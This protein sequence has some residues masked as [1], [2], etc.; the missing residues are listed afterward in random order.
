MFYKWKL[1]RLFIKKFDHH[2]KENIF[3]KITVYHKNSYK[4]FCKREL[5]PF[6]TLDGL[7][8]KSYRFYNAE[9]PWY[10]QI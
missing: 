1:E 3:L 6:L 9:L 10:G 8:I 5:Q 2:K 4:K 7:I